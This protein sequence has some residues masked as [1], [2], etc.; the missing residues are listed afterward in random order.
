MSGLHR[1]VYQDDAVWIG[2][3][4]CIYIKQTGTSRVEIVIKAP[5]SEAIRHQHNSEPETRYGHEAGPTG[6]NQDSLNAA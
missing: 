3:L 6:L 4:I 2:D 5:K 1:V